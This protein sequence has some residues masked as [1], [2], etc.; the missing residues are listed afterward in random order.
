MVLF[1]V[2][3]GLGRRMVSVL[4][5]FLPCVLPLFFCG[6]GVC[7]ETWVIHYTL[8][9]GTVLNNM[10][11]GMNA[12]TDEI[13]LFFFLLVLLPPGRLGPLSRPPTNERT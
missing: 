5:L 4:F 10:G 12:F 8:V 3:I 6:S 2:W 9:L 11:T 1:R 13:S 7:R